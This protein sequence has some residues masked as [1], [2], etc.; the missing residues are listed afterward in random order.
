ML[1]G[2]GGNDAGR[3][4]PFGGVGEEADGREGRDPPRGQGLAQSLHNDA[5]QGH[6]SAKRVRFLSASDKNLSHQE[7]RAL[8]EE[9]RPCARRQCARRSILTT[10]CE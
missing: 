3:D 2:P 5:G 4:S 1:A 7:W 9:R 10:A 8:T 6:F